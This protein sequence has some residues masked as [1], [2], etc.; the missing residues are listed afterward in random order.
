VSRRLWI[1]LDV[2]V[3]S[4]TV[5]IRDSENREAEVIKLSGDPMKVRRLFRR[6]MTSL[7]NQSEFC[8]ITRRQG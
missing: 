1:G 2:H 4:I 7:P 8:I 5:A 6:L 3:E